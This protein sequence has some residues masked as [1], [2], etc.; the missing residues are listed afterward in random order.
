[1]GLRSQL[2]PNSLVKMWSL[3]ASDL[4]AFPLSPGW[5]SPAALEFSLD[6]LAE[7]ADWRRLGTSLLHP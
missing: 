7:W 3:E 5:P 4:P 1:M 2:A 6:L